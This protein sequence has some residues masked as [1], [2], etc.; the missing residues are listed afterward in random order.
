MLAMWE[1]LKAALQLDIYD[2]N[3]TFGH[4]NPQLL[5]SPIRSL[6]RPG[7][8]IRIVSFLA[9]LLRSFFLYRRIHP[10]LKCETATQPPVIFLFITVNQ[11]KSLQPLV[12]QMP[13]ASFVGIDLLGSLNLDGAI[14]FP[15]FYMYLT[16]L[17]FLPLVLAKWLAA[18]GHRKLSFRRGFDNY[19]LIY[20]SYLAA[21]WWFRRFHLGGLVIADDHGTVARGFA[22][23]ARDE[24]VPVF[25]VQHASTSLKFPPLS[26]DYAFLD[27]MDSLHKYQRIGPVHSRVFLVGV[28]KGDHFYHLKNQNVQVTRIGICTNMLD[29]LERVDELCRFL[30]QRFPMLELALRPHPGDHRPKEWPKLA[31]HYAIRFSNAQQENPFE[32]LSKI[33]AII[34]GSSNIQLEAALMNVVPISYDFS[35]QGKNQ[36]GF[37]QYGFM[38]HGLVD[39]CSN[40]DELEICLDKLMQA[41]PDVSSRARYYCATAGTSF[42]GK[43]SLLVVGLLA[44]ITRYGEPDLSNWRRLPFEDQE[45]YEPMEMD[46]NGSAL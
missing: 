10:A 2:I 42:E 41:K 8:L 28:A 37:D 18:K 36:Y 23:A 21:R 27:G 40:L 20:G 38:E 6:G 17:P 14:P 44:S 46:R 9:R 13:G 43:S 11:K 35:Q 15:V 24:N 1:I 30:R 3:Y 32:F 5:L 34:A 39:Y 12:A 31:E 4:A 45:F 19:W 16:S 22:L 26:F 33:D 7:V 25:Y 29:P